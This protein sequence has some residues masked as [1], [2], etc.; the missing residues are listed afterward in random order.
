MKS[1]SKGFREHEASRTALDCGVG[2]AAKRCSVT[3]PARAQYSTASALLQTR[4]DESSL[5][6]T[7]SAAR[8]NCTRMHAALGVWLA[9]AAQH[10]SVTQGMCVLR[11]GG[12]ALSGRVC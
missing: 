8:C 9:R 12:C 1:S 6:H 5:V 10:V 2:G 4:H 3:H 11:P 7:V